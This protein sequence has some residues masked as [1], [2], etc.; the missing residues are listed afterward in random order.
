MVGVL[1]LRCLKPLG[2]HCADAWHLLTPPFAGSFPRNES[3]L[4]SVTFRRGRITDCLQAGL[5]LLHLG[6]NQGH[7]VQDPLQQAVLSLEFIFQVIK[8]AS[9]MFESDGE[10]PPPLKQF[11]FC[12]GL[13]KSRGS[14]RDRQRA[15]GAGA[16]T[17]AGA[18]LRCC[19]CRFGQLQ[20][21]FH[22]IS[23]DLVV[24]PRVEITN[25]FQ[26]LEWPKQARVDHSL[27][28]LVVFELQALETTRIPVV[29]CAFKGKIL[30]PLCQPVLL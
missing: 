17:I 3:E 28:S 21:S 10:S 26:S 16:A 24:I 30:N 9:L 13:L 27:L 23:L 19:K 18:V 22:S 7:F 5:G 6:F 8:H 11:K 14:F 12:F 15:C 25:V 20:F 29:H 4:F 2:W 1:C